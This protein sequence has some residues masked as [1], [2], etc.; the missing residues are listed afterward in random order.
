MNVYTASRKIWFYYI[1]LKTINKF[2]LRLPDSISD[3]R[4]YSKLGIKMGSTIRKIG[5]CQYCHSLCRIVDVTHFQ[6]HGENDETLG[7]NGVR[8]PR[9]TPA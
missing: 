6:R 9:P 4:F 8:H 3:K 7:D 1:T 5:Y 2:P